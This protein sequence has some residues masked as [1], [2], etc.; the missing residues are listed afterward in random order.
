[1]LTV[2]SVSGADHSG[3][4]EENE[5]TCREACVRQVQ[6]LAGEDAGGTGDRGGYTK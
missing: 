5:P 6:G 1:M 4:N 2:L 3:H